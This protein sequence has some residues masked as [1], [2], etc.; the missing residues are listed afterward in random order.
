MAKYIY[1]LA[2]F[3]ILYCIINIDNK[4]DKTFYTVK[5]TYP[6]LSKLSEQKN[7]ALIIQDLNNIIDIASWQEWPE[8][9]LW[10]DDIK[11]T[12]KWLVF[13]I[14]AFN[15]WSDKNVK[16]CP[17]IYNLLKDNDKIINIGFSRLSSGTVLNKHRGWANLS[18]YTLRCHLG[19]VI[20]GLAHIYCENDK[21]IQKEKKWIIFDDAKEHYA[22]NLGPTDRIVLILDIERPKNVHLGKSDV[23]DSK[24]L[25]TFTDEFM[26]NEK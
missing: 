1:L 8:Y 3:I 10:H 2:L 7:F 21:Q 22:D 15:K 18:N 19:L 24:E 16:L 17:N 23:M 14:K 9:D 25:L 26:R 4:M 13:P 5:E 12:N 6:E 11:Q 20:P